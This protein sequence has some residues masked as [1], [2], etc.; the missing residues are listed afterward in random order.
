MLKKAILTV[1]TLLSVALLWFAC[2]NYRQ[3]QPIAEE[4]LRG[5]ALSLSSAIEN[6][7]VHDSSLA[8]LAKFQ[9]NDI[10]YFALIDRRGVYR[11]HSNS[12][13]IGTAVMDAGAA[14]AW[15]KG[16]PSGTRLT[17]GTGEQAFQFTAPIVLSGSP[18]LLRLTLHTYRA[19]AVVRRAKLDVTILLA[20][21]GAGWLLAAAL[22]R[23]ARRDEL[24]QME[25]A[26]QENLAKLGELGA[27]LA[28]EIRNPLAGIKGFAQV[29]AKRPQEAR[30]AGF[31][32]NIVA[33]T[34]RLEHLVNELLDYA[35][36]DGPA[37]AGCDFAEVVAETVSL[38]A[39]EARGA[40]VVLRDSC[41]ERLHLLGV[42]D[43]LK[44]LLLNLCRN[45]LQ[46]MPEG[47]ELR[48]AA[49]AEDG[50]LVITLRDT[51]CGIE[52]GSLTKVFE[53]F[54]T[55]KAR[56]TGLGLAVCRKIAEQHRGTIG[57]ASVRGEG[58]TVTVTIPLQVGDDGRSRR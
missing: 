5:L 29:I 40:G 57:L 11:F 16:T 56:G 38:L 46:A 49:A 18:C 39:E 30:N 7:V 48:L 35:A 42:R 54:Y 37:P 31:A 53:P 6:L 23:Y 58:T 47:G 24:H 9:S 43:R 27:V 3:A 44:Q 36:A 52:E 12:G 55:T 34:V 17:L 21:L 28:H 33:E 1:A 2:Y 15:L 22:L 10:A 51:G 4:N 20:L 41:P 8:G 14:A 50:E 26:R 19:D 25:M 32:R 45:A 13:L